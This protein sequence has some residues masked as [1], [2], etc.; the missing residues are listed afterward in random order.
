MPIGWVGMHRI[1]DNGRWTGLTARE[2]RSV[3]R[4]GG[5]GALPINR[6]ES[7]EGDRERLSTF[8]ERLDRL[9]GTITGMI[10]PLRKTRQE[11]TSKAPMP[12]PRR[13]R[14]REHTLR[15]YAVLRPET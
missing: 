13:R 9:E 7:P 11:R 10:A 4:S 2:A 12:H 15:A 3:G 6:L 1:T 14:A 8:G 5:H